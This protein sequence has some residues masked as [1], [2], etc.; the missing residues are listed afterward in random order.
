M[1]YIGFLYLHLHEIKLL[2]S[3]DIYVFRHIFN[4]SET[5]FNNKR[6]NTLK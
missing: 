5:I 2:D 1:K 3:K 4:D 6:K